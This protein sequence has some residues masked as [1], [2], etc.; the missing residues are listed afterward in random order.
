MRNSQPL[1]MKYNSKVN[2]SILNGKVYVS[3][4]PTIETLNDI[5]DEISIV[6]KQF[7]LHSDFVNATD[8]QS[9]ADAF[10][11]IADTMPTLPGYTRNSDGKVVK[12][13]NYND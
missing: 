7:Q 4:D 12:D 11:K 9:S 3:D 1:T 6:A 2:M 5:V 8:L 10:R 13:V